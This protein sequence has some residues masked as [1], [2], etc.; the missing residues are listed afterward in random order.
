MFHNCVCENMKLYKQQ[1]NSYL[2]IE[3]LLYECTYYLLIYVTMSFYFEKGLLHKNINRFNM[4][5]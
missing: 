1:I 4:Q 3:T 2:E 5:V